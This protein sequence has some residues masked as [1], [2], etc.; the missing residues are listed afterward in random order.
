MCGPLKPAP[1]VV[2]A[3]VLDPGGVQLVVRV[4]RG[5]R[6]EDDMHV[7]HAVPAEPG[8]PGP[9]QPAPRRPPSPSPPVTLCSSTVSTAPAS[10]RR[11]R[12]LGG[13]ERR[14]RVH[15]DDPRA[16][17]RPRPAARPR[18]GSAAPASPVVMIARSVPSRS[19]MACP[20]REFRGRLGVHLRVAAPAHPDV[21][22]TVVV[23]RG[24]QDRPE[25]VGV[26]GADHGEPGD[27]PH[28]RRGPRGSGGW[29]RRSRGS[30][31]EWWARIRTGMPG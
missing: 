7:G 30:C 12:D 5:G 15:V 31:P 14:D 29:C 4:E 8:R 23:Q 22:G 16:D 25:L 20:M 13:V 18:P 27:R 10:L 21:H 11:G 6:A 24:S 19:R 26:G 28:D 1:A 9:R 3:P 17:A 2:L